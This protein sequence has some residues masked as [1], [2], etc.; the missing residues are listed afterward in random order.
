MSIKKTKGNPIIIGGVMLGGA[1][2]ALW[3][4]EFRFDYH[5]AASETEFVEHI[6][7]LEDNAI[8]SHTG[9]MDQSLKLKGDYAQEFIGY[10]TVRRR[11]E[12][13]A[14]DRDEDDDDVTWS[15][16]WMSNLEGNRRNRGLRKELE[17][18]T[19]RPEVYQ[20]GE[21]EIEPREI[22]F[23]DANETISP[24]SL[25]LTA[26][27]TSKKLTIRGS[28][29]YHS[30][31]QGSGGTKLG[32][33]RLSFSAIAVPEVATYFGK[34]N[35]RNAVKHQAEI[36][37]GLIP[38]IINDIGILHHI[39]A[40]ERVSA[41]VTIENHIKRIKNIVRIGG[42]IAAT[43]G[44]RLVFV[45]LTKFL[46]FIP[47]LGGAI[48]T[49]SGWI[50]MALGFLIGV[51]TIA[52]AFFSS[53]PMIMIVPILFIGIGV[54]FLKN[55]ANKKRETVKEHLNKKLGYSPS[56]QELKEL[57]YVKLWQ[58]L[59]RDGNISQSEQKRLDVWIKRNG[60]PLHKV[61]ALTQH[62]REELTQ[63]TNQ[64][65]SLKDL[66]KLTLA[67]GDIDKKELKTLKQAA[68]FIGLD[69]QELSRLINQVQIV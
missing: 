24:G 3:Q 60:F 6:S 51:F 39:V 41:L 53:N 33:E 14:W 8:F 37:D 26:K 5:K 13:Y 9:D 31:G 42:L 48:S 43:I 66:I 54:Y 30:K 38:S 22:Q 34:W 59:A 1:I 15:K 12:I 32:D 64:V 29:L 25:E 69:E 46:L 47:I 50:G 16:E 65:E 40:G 23:V 27:G 62:A 35:G 57:E 45:G 67:N 20:V 63:Q 49:A 17:S 2:A 7:N 28:Y 10:L 18:R 11:A 68:S 52:L 56:D 36:K 19:F 55:N 61:D 58:L 4:N 44:G 21:L